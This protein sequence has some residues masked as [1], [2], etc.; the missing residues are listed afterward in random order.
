MQL[1][2]KRI[3]Q[4]NIQNIT[5]LQQLTHMTFKV[6]LSFHWYMP[7]VYALTFVIIHH[8]IQAQ[9]MSSL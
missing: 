2:K 3:S 1:D 9:N 7:I 8:E 6:R 4:S 5:I